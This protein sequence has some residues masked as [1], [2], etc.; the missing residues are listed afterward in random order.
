M[1]SF[2]LHSGLC[3]KRTTTEKAFGLGAA[4]MPNG[5][6]DY[7][8]A[9][10]AAPQPLPLP[11]PTSG[12]NG[13]AEQRAMSSTAGT[14]SSHMQPPPGVVRKPAKAMQQHLVG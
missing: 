4:E 14:S 3:Q 7:P 11:P 10:A 2:L 1:P 12:S 5:E 9:A 6:E 13:S 8:D